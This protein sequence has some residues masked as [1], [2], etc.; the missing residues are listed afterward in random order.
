[1]TDDARTKL[2]QRW[3]REHMGLMLKVVR[4]CA[5]GHQDQDD[6][7]QEIL[8][9]LWISIPKWRG[10]SQESTWIYRVSFNTALLRTRG[11]RRRRRKLESYSEIVAWRQAQAADAMDSEL[12]E[13]LYAAIRRLSHVDASLAIMH[14]D[15]MT[16]QQM[17]EVLGISTNCIGVR[18]T[19]I[20]QQLANQL[21][22]VSDGL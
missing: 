3:L 17:S 18:L 6:L 12:V 11:E 20:R 7:L 8:L 2:F 13:R 1:M 4:S 21:A 22:G 5:S 19:R 15:G 16:Y 10:D 9:N 14:L